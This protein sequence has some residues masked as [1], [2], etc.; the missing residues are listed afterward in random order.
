MRHRR[1]G[2]QLSRD[3]EHR[4]SLRRNMAQ[5]LFE[6]GQITTTLPK[7]IEVQSFVEKLITRARTD[8]VHNRRLVVARLRDRRLTD[9]DQEFI[10]NDSGTH[11]TVVQKLFGEIA[12]Q[13]A[14][15]NGGYT[16]I[17]KLPKY[18]IGDGGDLVI[19]QLVGGDHE[20]EPTG[21]VRKASG[22]RRRRAERRREFANKV[23]AGKKS[24]TKAEAAPAAT[25]EPA[26]EAAESA[27][28]SE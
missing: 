19:L 12:P 7:A 11:R 1:R 3:T 21:V 24:D 14:D 18:R 9:A 20:S 27:P 16:R 6:H 8:N 15:R 5:S 26:A 4:I 13:Y 22:L 17:V 23:L 28:E 25:E 10:L 2:R